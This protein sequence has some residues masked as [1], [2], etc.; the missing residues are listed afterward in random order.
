MD[1][2]PCTKGCLWA[3]TRSNPSSVPRPQSKSEVVLRANPCQFPL[4]SRRQPSSPPMVKLMKWWSQRES[5]GVVAAALWSRICGH[6]EW[7]SHGPNIMPPTRW[8][9]IDLVCHAG[10]GD[11]APEPSTPI[12][13]GA[14]PS[15]AWG[16]WCKKEAE[17]CIWRR[18]IVENFS[19]WYSQDKDWSHWMAGYASCHAEPHGWVMCCTATWSCFQPI[20]WQVTNQ[21]GHD[22]VRMPI[23]L[24]DV[25]NSMTVCS[26]SG[27]EGLRRRCSMELAGGGGNGTIWC[28]QP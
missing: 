22:S 2:S 18:S 8:C 7:K 4:D 5:K 14:I 16:S 27:T 11:H 9:W 15:Q 28:S 25:P 13:H 26:A 23:D 1:I 12:M 6:E 19:K 20:A 21:D 17:P 3:G 10:G 24:Y